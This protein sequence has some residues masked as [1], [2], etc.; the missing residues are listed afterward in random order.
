MTVKHTEFKIKGKRK[1]H[2]NE[3]NYPGRPSVEIQNLFLQVMEC[4]E[5][6]EMEQVLQGTY[7]GDEERTSELFD[8]IEV[9]DIIGVATFE[10]GRGWVPAQWKVME[11]PEG[12]DVLTCI[13]R[14]EVRKDENLEDFEKLAERRSIYYEDISIGLLM[15][16]AEILLRGDKPFGVSEEVEYKVL[17]PYTVNEERVAEIQ[18]EEDNSAISDMISEG[19]PVHAEV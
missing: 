15:G 12:A 17:L 18:A 3:K 7:I 1:L 10:E 19:G 9:G 8:S 13:P 5:S 11:I 4:L 6:D 16:R 14:I 2:P